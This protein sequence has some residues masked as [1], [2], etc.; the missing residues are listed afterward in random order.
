MKNHYDNITLLLAFVFFLLEH[1]FSISHRQTH[2]TMSVDNVALKYVF[3]GPRTPWSP[4]HFFLGVNQS[5]HGMSF[6]YTYNE[7]HPHAREVAYPHSSLNDLP[8]D[9]ENKYSKIYFS[10]STKN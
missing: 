2:W 7:E 6:V 1:L 10:K 4:W 8:E 9:K 5:G 3:W